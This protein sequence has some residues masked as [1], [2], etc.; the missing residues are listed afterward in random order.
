MMRIQCSLNC[1]QMKNVPLHHVA[2]W[3]ESGPLEGAMQAS[4][5]LLHPELQQ[6]L[7]IMGHIALGLGLVESGFPLAQFHLAVA[8]R[9]GEGCHQ[10]EPHLP[11][12][13]SHLDGPSLRCKPGQSKTSHYHCP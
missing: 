5:D 3:E 6:L 8:G 13:G 7:P 4:L 10:E 1:C 11:Q 2:G 9:M 12:G